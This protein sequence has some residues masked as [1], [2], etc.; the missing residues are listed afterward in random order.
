MRHLKVI[1]L[2]AVAVALVVFQRP[3]GI[4]SRTAVGLNALGVSATITWHGTITR[5]FVSGGALEISS[6]DAPGGV[7]HAYL[8]DG[9]VSPITEGEVTITG[10]WTGWTCDYGMKC[11]PEVE[12]E[13]VQ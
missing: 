9:Q 6:S 10:R 11:V 12:V 1:G 7:F 2:I 8:S 3:L 5:T 4:G 13:R